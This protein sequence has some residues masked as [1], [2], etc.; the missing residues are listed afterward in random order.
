[1]RFA[2]NVVKILY[3]SNNGVFPYH[4]LMHLGTQR[5]FAHAHF[6]ATKPV[7][8]HSI[9]ILFFCRLPVFFNQILG[10]LY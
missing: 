10:Y 7:A 4:Q 9:Y 8:E 3:N 2:R 5:E 6:Q 1:M